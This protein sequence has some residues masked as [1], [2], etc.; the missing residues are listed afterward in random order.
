[1][2]IFT[3]SI[4]QLL[5]VADA[6]GF[7]ELSTLYVTGAPQI[8]Q[9]EKCSV[10]PQ[11]QELFVLSIKSA[12]LS[13]IIDKPFCIFPSEARICDGT[14]RSH[15]ITDILAAFEKVTFDHNTFNQLS[16]V[17]IIVAAVKYF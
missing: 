9:P 4:C 12:F 8:R 6:A 14:A 5:F 1:M 13:N 11:Q 10:S 2:A 15:M 16:E 3:D 17:W 7:T